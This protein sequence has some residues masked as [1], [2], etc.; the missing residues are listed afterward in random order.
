MLFGASR[1][2]RG[3]PVGGVKLPVRSTYYLL[4]FSSAGKRE[5]YKFLELGSWKPFEQTG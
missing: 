5:F 2:R 3:S 4:D 1:M